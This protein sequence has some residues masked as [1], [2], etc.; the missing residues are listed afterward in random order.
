MYGV[1]FDNKHSYE[2]YELILNSKSISA[3][4]PKTNTI[5]IPGADGSIDLTEA[6]TGDIKYSNRTIK[7]DLTYIGNYR[8]FLA[9][10]SEL[11]NSLHGKKMNITFDDDTYYY[12][13]GRVTLNEWKSD[14]TIGK[15]SVEIDAEPYKYEVQSSTQEW[16]WDGFN[17]ETGVIR[18]LSNIVVDGTKEVIVIGSTKKV[19][20]TIQAS[21]DMKVTYLTKI[22][23]LTAGTNKVY[24]ISLSQGENKLIFTGNGTITIEYRGGTL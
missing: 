8:D 22:Y 6:L 20:P 17:F 16:L 12:Y 4:S 13:V 18:E 14:K 7:C 3:P 1:K 21:A 11:Q 19:I 15:I 2:E 5:D 9:K 23:D 10:W 24:D